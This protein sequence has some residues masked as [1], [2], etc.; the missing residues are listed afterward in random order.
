MPNGDDHDKIT[1]MKK[2]IDFIKD[3]LEKSCKNNGVRFDRLEVL[4]K[5]SSE[6]AK[7]SAIK[8]A[9]NEVKSRMRDIGNQMFASKIVETIVF[10][11][12]KIILVAFILSV[13]GFIGWKAL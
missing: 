5:E 4:I 11:T 2:D 6:H 9:S 3:E 1:C 8:Y 12:I 13:L 7:N 10:G